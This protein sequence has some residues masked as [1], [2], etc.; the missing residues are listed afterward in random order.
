MTE[1]VMD[2]IF[3]V[4][5]IHIEMELENFIFKVDAFASIG[6]WF[7]WTLTESVQENSFS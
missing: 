7:G 4:L 6:S 2:L 3:L 1:A 5:A